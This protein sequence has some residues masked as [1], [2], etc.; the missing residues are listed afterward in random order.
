MASPATDPRMAQ[1][2][3]EETLIDEGKLHAAIN[4][5]ANLAAAA[6]NADDYLKFCQGV[7]Q[8]IAALIAYHQP[9]KNPNAAPPQTQGSP[10]RGGNAQTPADGGTQQ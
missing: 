2:Q 10:E 3:P 4:N 8:V 7:E 6:S 5:G 9:I 1:E